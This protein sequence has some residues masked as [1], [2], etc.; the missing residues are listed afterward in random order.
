MLGIRT[1]A[2]WVGGKEYMKDGFIHSV[3]Q[4]TFIHSRPICQSQLGT[5]GAQAMS[6]GPFL[7]GM[8]AN[9]S[10]KA[11]CAVEDTLLPEV[12]LGCSGSQGAD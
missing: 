6:P 11:F 4:Q 12:C 10:I 9:M 1:P 7:A 2:W 5:E 8:D 3:M